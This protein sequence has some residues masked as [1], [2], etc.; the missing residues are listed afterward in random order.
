M[1]AVQDLGDLY[2]ILGVEPDV[3]VKQIEK[4]YRKASLKCH[5]D[6]N[7]DD[8]DAA[9]KFDRL[10]RAKEFLLAPSK[11][12][13]YDEKRKKEESRLKRFKEHNAQTQAMRLDLERRELEA[14]R[15]HAARV[16]VTQQ[17]SSNI[18]ADFERAMAERMQKKQDKANET[19][20]KMR[21]TISKLVKV[22]LILASNNMI[23]SS[24]IM[25][26]LYELLSPYKLMKVTVDD[27]SAELMF[28]TKEKAL[29]A[30]QVLEEKKSICGFYKKT[31]IEEGKERSED[32]IDELDEMLGNEKERINLKSST[33]RDDSTF[34]L[35]KKNARSS[36]PPAEEK[37]SPPKKARKE[38]SADLLAELDAMLM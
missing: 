37:P 24:S 31:L 3:T 29:E 4:A 14:E 8:K 33:L 11:R 34:P 27:Y 26:T 2:K 12:A 13:L 23:T 30:L 9:E 19:D 32:L 28:E 35:P 22:T 5:P 18:K 21:Q 10:T 15:M 25:E 16:Q 17:V 6:R 1:E 20:R 7:K 36:P 38:A